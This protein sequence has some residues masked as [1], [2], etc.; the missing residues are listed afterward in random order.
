MWSLGKIK[1]VRVYVEDWDYV[2]QNF[3]GGSNPEKFHRL[4]VNVQKLLELIEM[5]K[6][7]AEMYKEEVKR[8]NDLVIRQAQEIE[9]LK[10]YI[11]ECCECDDNKDSR[12]KKGG[13][14][15]F[16]NW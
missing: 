2:N 15:G 7:V 12:K 11:K 16:L 3:S 9:E 4:I 5:Y 6:E 13:L 8:L 14:L 1:R 10:A